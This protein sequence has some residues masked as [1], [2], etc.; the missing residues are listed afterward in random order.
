VEIE[1]APERENRI[2]LS[3]ETDA[4]GQPKAELVL[5]LTEAEK[6]AHASSLELAGTELG[7][8]GRRLARLMS[9]MLS[10]GRF[11]FYWH[12]MGSTR[13]HADSRQGVVDADCRVHGVANLFVAGSS[14]FPTSG[15]APPTLTIVALALRL[16][17]HIRLGPVYPGRHQTDGDLRERATLRAD[18]P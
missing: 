6:R 18:H 5:R 11:N 13:M 17:D 15:I 14:V 4:C 3:A 2:R 8:N 9:F 10:A 16:A 12:H 7:L 1:Q